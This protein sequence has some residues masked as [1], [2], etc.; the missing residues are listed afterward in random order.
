[1][2]G[3]FPNKLAQQILDIGPKAIARPLGLIPF[4]LKADLLKRILGLLLAEQAADE[5][6]DFLEGRWVA[7]YIKDLALSF[8]V[9]YADGWQVRPIQNAEVTFTAQS[10]ELLLIAAAKEDPDSLFFQRKLCIEGDTELG[11]EVK[12]L[13]LSVE[14]DAM[15]AAIRMTIEKLALALQ[16][17]QA[18]AEPALA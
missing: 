15:P 8:E 14:F 3:F 6:L 11:L 1:M 12:N 18:K 9:T 5:E 10:K 7:I 4:A 17:L 13:L 16:A 2:Q